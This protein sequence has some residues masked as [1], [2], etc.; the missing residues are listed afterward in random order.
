VD[1]TSNS[2][3]TTSVLGLLLVLVPVDDWELLKWDTPIEGA[4][5]LV[6]LLLE[7]LE[8]TLLDLVLLELLQVVRKTK[9]LPDED[10]PL[11]Q[12]VLPPF[13]GVAVIGREFV[14]EVVVT[15]AKSD[16]GSDGVVT[17]RVSVVEWLVSEPMGQGVD[18]EG[19]LL[20][21][22]DTKDTGVDETT[23]PVSPSNTGDKH[24]E[25]H[26]HEDDGLDVVAVLP[27]D[28]WVV[29]EVGDIGTADSLWVLL[30]DHPSDVRVEK[31]LA[32]GV[33][34]LVGVGVSVVGT[35]I[36]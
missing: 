31:T 5:L 29:V 28:D 9:L 16:K 13:N 10:A 33:W 3:E 20:N 1:N 27:D 6:E 4:S 14:V 25:D 2:D 30:H 22:E 36:S 24:G 18:T 15:L 7:L 32:D 19:G 26:S 8:T 35:M 23:E 12:V 11:G 34:V 17:R 21:E